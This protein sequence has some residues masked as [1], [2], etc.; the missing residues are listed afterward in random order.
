MARYFPSQDLVDQ[1]LV[2]ESGKAIP[3]YETQAYKDAVT[4]LD[5]TSLKEG[6]FYKESDWKALGLRTGWEVSDKE[7]MDNTEKGPIITRYGQV[8]TDKPDIKI[9][10]LIYSN[11]DK[12]FYG[13]IVYDSCQWLLNEWVTT[14]IRGNMYAGLR[15]DRKSSW[16][17]TATGYYWRKGVYDIQPRMY[18]GNK[19]NYHYV[20]CR[21]S[22]MYLNLAEIYLLENNVPKAVEMLN[23]ARVKHG[24]LPASTATTSEDAWKDYIRERRVEM[25]Q[26]NDLYWSYLRWGK[27][28]GPANEGREPGAVIKALDNPPYKIMITK[29]RKRFFIAQIMY[30]K[31]MEP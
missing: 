4:E 17:T 23:V 5:P 1:Y 26:E 16:Y 12:R 9:N 2:V 6:D 21:L 11:R 8:K 24:E 27:Y 14:C 15:P 7:D 30:G 18:A 20:L 13:T 25:A 31:N 22:E 10:E 28:G 29:D 3:W 19:T